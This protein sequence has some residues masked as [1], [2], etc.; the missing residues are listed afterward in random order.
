MPKPPP[1]VSRPNAPRQARSQASLDRIVA[2]ARHLLETH[3]FEELTVTAIVR[4]A[5]SSVGVF[6]SRFRDKEAL[7]DHLDELYAAEVIESIEAIS[8][9]RDLKAASLADFALQLVRLL[10]D[11]HR[12]RRGMIRAL[13]LQARIRRG[14]RFAERTR[15]MNTGGEKIAQLILDHRSEIRHPEPQ[16]AVHLVLLFLLTAVRELTL[17]PEGPAAWGRADEKSIQRELVHMF[18][19]YLDVHD[20]DA[21]AVPRRGR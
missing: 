9:R 7:L 8:E 18:L 10:L 15:R 21:H 14:G 11:F 16:L 20:P 19:R 3:T 12:E 1:S 4:E 17:F 5:R 13:I 6:Y 2:A